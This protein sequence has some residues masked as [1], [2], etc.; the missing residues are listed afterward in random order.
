MQNPTKHGARAT[1]SIEEDGEKTCDRSIY[2]FPFPSRA[3]QRLR[4]HLDPECDQRCE[5]ERGHP[6]RLRPLH[7]LLEPL[8]LGNLALHHNI[9]DIRCST[10]SFILVNSKTKMISLCQIFRSD[11]PLSYNL[12]LASYKH[13]LPVGLPLHPL[14]RHHPLRGRGLP[15]Q[16]S[17]GLY[18]TKM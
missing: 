9:R 5:A 11:K 15:V 13:H 10:I 1:S 4:G 3:D 7:L 17:Q 2:N 8:R 12:S 16:Q 14:R 6:L 18:F